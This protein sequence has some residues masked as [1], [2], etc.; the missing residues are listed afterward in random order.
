[1]DDEHVNLFRHTFEPNISILPVGSSSFGRAIATISDDISAVSSFIEAHVTRAL[2]A[3]RNKELWTGPRSA[4]KHGLHFDTTCAGCAGDPKTLCGN[5]FRS[6]DKEL[7]ADCHAAL[8]DDDARAAYEEVAPMAFARATES[9]DDD[10][11]LCITLPGTR[12]AIALLV[13]SAQQ[14]RLQQHDVDF[15]FL[16]E[17]LAVANAIGDAGDKLLCEYI[18][19]CNIINVSDDRLHTDI[20]GTIDGVRADPALTD[21]HLLTLLLLLPSP[22][23]RI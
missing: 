13:R 9:D 14:A 11:H 12:R 21:L 19:L 1:M 5:L 8:P 23:P 17:D 3:Q 18:E 10:G 4:E 2:A 20:I 22:P 16:E 6:A 7:C 15:C